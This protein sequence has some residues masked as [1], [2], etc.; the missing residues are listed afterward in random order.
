[1]VRL[2]ISKTTKENSKKV[3]YWV[4]FDIK[5]KTPTKLIDFQRFVEVIFTMVGKTGFER[6]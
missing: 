2:C 6:H 5:E 4:C 3:W 1:M